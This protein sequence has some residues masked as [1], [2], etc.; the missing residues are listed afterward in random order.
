VEAVSGR[1]DVVSAAGS[2]T[3]VTARIP[4]PANLIDGAAG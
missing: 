1:L 4:V 3:T 2:G